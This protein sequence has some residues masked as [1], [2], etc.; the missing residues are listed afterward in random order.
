MPTALTPEVLGT[1]SRSRLARCSPM[2]I[3]CTGGRGVSVTI[4]FPSKGDLGH[5]LRKSLDARAGVTC[6]T[7]SE[8][9]GHQTT[10][11]FQF[12]S[13]G[14]VVLI[15]NQNHE[16]SLLAAASAKSKQRLV[17]SHDK[18][19]VKLMC[20]VPYPVEH[21]PGGVG[22]GLHAEPWV[23]ERVGELL[24]QPADVAHEPCRRFRRHVNL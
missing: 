15:K 24:L 4:N 3:A 20:R 17:P 22:D 10:F 12:L 14:A 1:A 23:L 9:H 19:P 18:I 6:H 8:T 2:G 16:S 7:L 21:G 5:L 13:T 11:F